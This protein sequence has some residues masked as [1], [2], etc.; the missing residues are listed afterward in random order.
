VRVQQ[1]R[2]RA[3]LKVSRAHYARWSVC[4]APQPAALIGGRERVQLPYYDDLEL[5]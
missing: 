3:R 5:S 4:E 1:A 2:Q